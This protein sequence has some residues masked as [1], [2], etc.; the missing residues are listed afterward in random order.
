MS[1]TL[2]SP[3]NLLSD[4]ITLFEVSLSSTIRCALLCLLCSAT[5][6]SPSTQDSFLLTFSRCLY[7]RLSVHIHIRLRDL[8]TVPPHS[9]HSS[10]V[11]VTDD[12]ADSAPKTAHQH[13]ANVCTVEDELQRMEVIYLFYLTQL[14]EAHAQQTCFALRQLLIGCQAFF[15]IFACSP[16]FYYFYLYS[17]HYSSYTRTFEHAHM[18][19]TWS[20]FVPNPPFSFSTL[21]CSRQLIV[22]FSVE[23]CCDHLVLGPLL[24]LSACPHYAL[25]PCLGAVL[26]PLV[27][28]EILELS[29]HRSL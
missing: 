4:P 1:R 10:L 25:H 23:G 18:H 20:L 21:H 28:A 11:G 29:S 16:R 9:Q 17:F 19:H 2:L 27:L 5:S 13:D 8:D 6:L 24:S 22:S 3:P 26:I 12:I 14:L 15:K 7:P